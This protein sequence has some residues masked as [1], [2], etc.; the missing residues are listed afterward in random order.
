MTILSPDPV[1][2]EPEQKTC[3]QQ[4]DTHQDHVQRQRDRHHQTAD[5]S[6]EGNHPPVTLFGT[7]LPQRGD[8]GDTVIEQDG[9]GCRPH[10]EFEGAG[11]CE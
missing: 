4:P 8:V 5:Q 3:N 2:Q 9:E 1:K 11:Q 7:R 10:D 6:K